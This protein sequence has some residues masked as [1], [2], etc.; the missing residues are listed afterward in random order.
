MSVEYSVESDILQFLSVY[1]V[2]SYY[3]DELQKV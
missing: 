2:N 1:V 3:Y